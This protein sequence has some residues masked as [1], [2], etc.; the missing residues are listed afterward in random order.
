M[1]ALSLFAATWRL[2]TPQTVYPQIPLLPIGRIAPLWLDWAGLAG[3]VL[4]LSVAT[5]AGSERTWGRAALWLF[6][7]SV[8]GMIVLDQHRLQPW[9]YQFLLIALVLS[10]RGGN[11][12]VALLRALAIG[13]YFW[14][15]LGKFDYTF[16]HGLGQQF[17]AT[18]TGWFG[19]AAEDWPA[20]ARV[21]A[22]A[23]FPAGELLTAVGLCFRRT[24][25]PA[26]ILAVVMHAGLV[27]LLGPWGLDHQPGVLLWNGFFAAQAIILFTPLPESQETEAYNTHRFGAAE[28]LIVL[29]VTLPVLEAGGRWDHWPSWG[30]YSTRAEGARIYVHRLAA[31]RLP[32]DLQAHLRPAPPGEDWRELEIDR[33]SLETLAAP[34]YP[35]A[36]FQLGVAE[37]VGRRYEL[38]GFIQAVHYHAADRW[39]GRRREEAHIGVDAIAEAI[40]AMLLHGHPRWVSLAERDLHLQ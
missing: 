17:L 25:L 8:A 15:A 36:R 10:S 2:W 19:V 32:E 23:L 39:T 24:R 9:A 37:A 28:L 34:V 22:A 16:L 26:V 30:L 18:M 38:G 6:A 27:A 12:A 14:S 13:V 1:L 7:I 20:T 4:S 35:Q 5:V 29:A 11:R 3:I 21:A 40:D 33:W 31:F